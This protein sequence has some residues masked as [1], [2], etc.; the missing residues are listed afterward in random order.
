M[1]WLTWRQFRGPALAVLAGLAVFGIA[2]A[3]T[4]PRLAQEYHLSGLAACTG[5]T[6]CGSA[7]QLFS[8]QVKRTGIDVPLYFLGV[9]LTYLIAAVIGMFWGAPLVA[10]ELESGTFR[11]A[12]TQGVTRTRWLAVKLTLVGL[13]A[14]TGTGLLSLAVTWWSRPIDRASALPAADAGL[15]L[16]DRF[17]PLIFGSRGIAPIGYAAFAFLLGVA[18][19]VTLRRT[20]PA[21]A[22]TL[23]V[24]AGVQVL[25]P[26]VLRGHYQAP[27]VSTT[28]LV[29]TPDR[30]QSLQLRD[31]K[32]TVVAPVTMPGAWITSVRTVDSAGR[33]AVPAI[34]PA[35]ADPAG[36]LAECDEAI[37][38]LRL[39]QRV[40]YH[41]AGRFWA[42]QWYE[43]GLYLAL[44]T[45]LVAVCVRRIRR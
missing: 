25:V 41:P 3:V 8:F 21:M 37:N 17:A 2:L 43:L 11:L 5:G 6:D 44:T 22:F 31:G 14:M 1:I 26:A 36:T 13:A 33:T 7:P 28:A 42:F 20:V 29:L 40:A 32:L 12:W 10:R 16:P 9:A 35:C 4:G 45:L 34:P 38:A 15:A 30:P 27:A 18:A 39:R 23:A 19:G 24:L